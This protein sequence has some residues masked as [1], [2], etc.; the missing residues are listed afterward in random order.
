VPPL[1]TDFVQ[2]P[3]IGAARSAVHFVLFLVCL[4]SG[5]IRKPAARDDRR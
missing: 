3:R 4:Y 1:G 2:T 5:F